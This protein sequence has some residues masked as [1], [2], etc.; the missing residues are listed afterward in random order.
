MMSRLVKCLGDESGATAI[1]Y[2]LML[3]LMTIVCIAGFTVLGSGSGG[4]WAT[5]GTTLGGALR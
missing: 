2:G 4:M 5:L 1:E 3:A